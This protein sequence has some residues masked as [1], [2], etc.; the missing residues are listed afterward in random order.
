MRSC[1]P[2]SPIPYLPALFEVCFM[3]DSAIFTCNNSVIAVS[4]TVLLSLSPDYHLQ[5]L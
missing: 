1:L 3:L 4:V 2:I 5:F